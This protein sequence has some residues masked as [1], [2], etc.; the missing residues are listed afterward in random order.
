M[1]PSVTFLDGV[2]TQFLAEIPLS[3]Y[4]ATPP[5]FVRLDINVAFQK[6]IAFVRP[7]RVPSFP[8]QKQFPFAENRTFSKSTEFPV[9][10]SF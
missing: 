10:A 6:T 3:H 7:S 8:Y 4:S 2:D 9:H 1:P 5:P